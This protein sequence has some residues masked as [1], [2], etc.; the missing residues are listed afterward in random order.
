[1]MILNFHGVRGSH[2]VA[3][4]EMMKYGGGTACVEIV[5]T[6]RNG[7]KVPIVI[8]GGSGLIKYGYSLAKSLF[9][10]EYSKTFPFLFTHVHPDHIEGFNFFLP[11]YFG[12]CT[13]HIMGMESPQWDI[14]V[15]LRNRMAAPVFPTEY[16][17]LKSRR[18][19]RNLADGNVVYIDQNG[20]PQD[21]TDDPLFE[22]RVMRA[23]APSHP[24]QG[25]LYFRISD[26]EDG[27]SIACIWDIES[28][29]GG[30]V[31]VITFAKDADVMIHDTQYTEE[32]YADDKSPVQGF[33]HSTY[34]MA[35][36]N[37]KKAGV[38][39][40][41]AFHYSPRHNDHFLDKIKRKYS[42]HSFGFYM[43]YEGLSLTLDKGKLT[44]NS[45]LNLKFAK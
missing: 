31:R 23:F 24:Q 14:D 42:R 37:T 20:E 10:G 27:S 32:E 22:I 25:V 17:D 30:D 40:L 3:D 28:H 43:S 5:K 16:R 9:A 6:N 38:K 36:E 12:F 41:I 39:N 4:R 33:G 34:T 13:L 35:V 26:P 8:D 1:M 21:K 29:P 45:D 19:Y 15:V 18:I 11:V 44:K 7:I 2:P